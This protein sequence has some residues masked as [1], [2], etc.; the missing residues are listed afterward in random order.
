M[1][2]GAKFYQR[3]KSIFYDTDHIDENQVE[4][5]KLCHECPG[6]ATVMSHGFYHSGYRNQVYC[7]SIPFGACGACYSEAHD[8]YR[9]SVRK[10]SYDFV[11]LQNK[12]DDIYK[13]YSE[14][15]KKEWEEV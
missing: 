9:E 4:K 12:V 15:A 8:E 2:K 7:I 13:V 14:K 10:G 11:Y 5:V 1:L 3:N 6:F